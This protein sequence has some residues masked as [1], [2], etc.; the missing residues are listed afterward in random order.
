MG[1]VKE[2]AARL[3]EV[4][5]D[6]A[7]WDDLMYQ[8]YVRQ[9]AESGDRPA[10]LRE[11]GPTEAAPEGGATFSQRWRGKFVPAGRDDERYRALAKSP[12]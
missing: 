7:T 12:R 10:E 4:L 8:V 1:T 5:P 11:A 9:K 6:H 3:V 2:Q